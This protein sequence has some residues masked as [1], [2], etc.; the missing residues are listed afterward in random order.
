MWW[1]V[2]HICRCLGFTQFGGPPGI[3]PQLLNVHQHLMLTAIYQLAHVRLMYW[4]RGSWREKLFNVRNSAEAVKIISHHGGIPP[5]AFLAA[6]SYPG[7][8]MT[9]PSHAASNQKELDYGH[10][11]A[12]GAKRTGT[13]HA[14]SENWGDAG[15]LN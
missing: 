7:G 13:Q 6:A 10:M 3:Y 5:Q 8:G 14:E 9:K 12:F 1:Y 11:L 4:I 15:N 2:G